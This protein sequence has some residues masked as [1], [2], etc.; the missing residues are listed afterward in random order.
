MKVRQTTIIIAAGATVALYRD[1]ARRERRVREGRL[2]GTAA[3]DGARA[4][5]RARGHAGVHGNGGWPPGRLQARGGARSPRRSEPL[6]FG[7]ICRLSEQKVGQIAQSASPVR[8]VE[9]NR[10]RYRIGAG[11][12]SQTGR[13]VTQKEGLH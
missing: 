2:A 12:P 3:R 9:R 13:A 8:V 4:R 5:S 6:Q 10:V 7:A 11:L 1:S